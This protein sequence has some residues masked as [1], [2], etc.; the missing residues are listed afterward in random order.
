ME[1]LGN[2]IGVGKSAIKKYE[3]GTV[4]NIP[5]ERIEKIALATGTTEAALMGWISDISTKKTME[6]KLREEIIDLISKLD[7]TNL[8]LVINLLKQLTKKDS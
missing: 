4:T 2:S 7:E 3:N 6:E 5:L 8:N 1:E